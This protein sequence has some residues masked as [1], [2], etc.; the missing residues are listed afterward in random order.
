MTGGF[1]R[2][3]RASDAAGLARVQVAS[4]RA[5]L[6]GL[7][8]DEVIDRADQLGGARPVHRALAA[9][10]SAPAD[11]EAPGARRGRRAGVGRDRR[12]RRRRARDRR[13]P[14]AGD[15][16]RSCTSCTCD[17]PPPPAERRARRAAAA[18][19]R[20]HV[21]RGRLPHRLHLGAGGGRGADR[22]PLGG[23]LG[24]GRQHVQPR[25]GRQGT[26]GA[27]AHPAVARSGLDLPTPPVGLA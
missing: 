7:V 14:V 17:C 1:V 15:R 6:A 3:A 19:G 11:V 23:R 8:P 2:A 5:T 22:L 13:G 16:R 12:V 25:H 4:W 24:T 18:R 10:R 26:G 20:G 9:R 27:P 21:R